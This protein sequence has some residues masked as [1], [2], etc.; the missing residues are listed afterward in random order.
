M[1]AN[2]HLFQHTEDTKTYTAGQVIFKQGQPGDVMY[3]VQEGEVDILL[4]DQVLETVEAGGLLGELAL[5]DKRPRTATAVARTNCKIISID[6][7]RFS[8]L[9]QETPFFA[10]RVMET[11]AERIRHMDALALQ[12]Y[13][14]FDVLMG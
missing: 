6:E 8:F 3:I 7:Y 4:A 12:K 13:A 1:Q 9:V 10:L 2:F 14:P 5:I 11:M